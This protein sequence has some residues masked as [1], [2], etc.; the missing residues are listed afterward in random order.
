MFDV[1]QRMAEQRFD[2]IPMAENGRFLY[3][4]LNQDVSELYRL[5][6]SHPGLRPTAALNRG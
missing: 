2:A 6:A 1:Q 3:L 4:L 5:A